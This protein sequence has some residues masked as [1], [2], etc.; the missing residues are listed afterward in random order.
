[1]KEEAA[2]R[3]Q[4]EEVVVP[5]P[6]PLRPPTRSA[7]TTRSTVVQPHSASTTHSGSSSWPIYFDL[8]KSVMRPDAATLKGSL[9]WFNQN[10]ER[11]VR[12]EGIATEG[13]KETT[14][15]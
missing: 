6:P 14:I 9:G 3:P 8:N 12:I 13:N 1:M 10:Q 4:Q 15:C 5:P 2:P 11:K 7:S